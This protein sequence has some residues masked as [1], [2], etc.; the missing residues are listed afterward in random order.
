L[1]FNY[2]EKKLIINLPFLVQMFN[3]DWT[4]N[5]KLSKSTK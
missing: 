4:K 3:E 2:Q 1:F 5:K